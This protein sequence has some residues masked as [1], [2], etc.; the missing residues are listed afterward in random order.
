LPGGT[1][2]LRRTGNSGKHFANVKSN[3]CCSITNTAHRP[4][5]IL[6][7]STLNDPSLNSIQNAAVNTHQICHHST[8]E[9]N[10]ISSVDK[11]KDGFQ[12]SGNETTK[13]TQLTANAD[14][15]RIDESTGATSK[16]FQEP[17]EISVKR[18]AE[19]VERSQ[20]TAGE[21][22]E[23]TADATSD[24]YVDETKHHQ[25]CT[26]KSASTRG[27]SKHPSVHSPNTFQL[28]ARESAKRWNCENTNHEPTPRRLRGQATTAQDRAGFS[29][30]GPN[31]TQHPDGDTRR[32][33]EDVNETRDKREYK[34]RMQVREI[35]PAKETK[36]KVD[37][38]ACGTRGSEERIH[39]ECRAHISQDSI[40]KKHTGVQETSGQKNN[41][42]SDIK[43]KK[44]DYSAC[45]NKK[46]AHS[47]G[48]KTEQVENQASV[49]NKGIQRSSNG[50][51]KGTDDISTEKREIGGLTEYSA[52]NKGKTQEGSAE[53]VVGNFAAVKEEQDAE[54]TD[55]ATAGKSEK[56][57]Q[58]SGGTMSRRPQVLKITDS[59]TTAFRRQNGNKH[60]SSSSV[61]LR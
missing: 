41:I 24:H 34:T 18:T 40:E 49:K 16:T 8:D 29:G 1:S 36:T 27:D 14:T 9:P 17:T 57:R 50:K 60:V 39:T 43:Y 45:E 10:E 47:T 56:L 38:S 44:E 30:K 32:K 61:V 15:R 54:A 59:A 4:P 23:T 2:A 12:N 46:Q 53:Q 28:S 3:A 48:D 33:R 6:A 37:C 26:R 7:F 5:R 22:S 31:K 55:G 25:D 35:D 11:T 21:S 42:H 58:D 51:L 52:G 20:N 19:A 13:L